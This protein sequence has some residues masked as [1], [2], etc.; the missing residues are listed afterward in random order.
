M[1]VYGVESKTPEMDDVTK[2]EVGHI[3]VP[4]RSG[5]N[6]LGANGFVNLKIDKKIARDTLSQG[7]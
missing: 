7:S 6:I 1:E 3:V 2:P 4:K 5:F